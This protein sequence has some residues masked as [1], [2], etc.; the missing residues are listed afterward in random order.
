MDCFSNSAFYTLQG[1]YPE[2]HGIVGN[3]IYDSKHN[4]S[5]SIG[6]SEK[7]EPFWW[8]GE[9][10]STYRDPFHLQTYCTYTTHFH[11]SITF[12]LL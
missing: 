9:P 7:F 5:F 8:G 10:V 2:S 3:N 6:G 4:M 11:L 12:L 1:L